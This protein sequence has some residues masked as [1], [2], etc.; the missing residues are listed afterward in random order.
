MNGKICV[1]YFSPTKT[2]GKIV[3]SLVNVLAQ[4]TGK[5]KV[6]IDL[7]L[8]G[9]RSKEYVFGPDDVLVFGFPVY[10]GR[11]PKLLQETLAKL[12]SDHSKA[13]IS[14]TYGNRE[15]E[16]ALLEAKDIIQT[17]GFT[18]VAACALIGEHSFS[19]KLAA[20]RPDEKDMASA[21]RFAQQIADK[22][23]AGNFQE[24]S[25]KG[26]QP[27]REEMPALPFLPKT[28]DACTNCLNCVNVCPLG[29]IDANDPKIVNTGCIQCC[30]CVKS[31]P[32]EAKYFDD[33]NLTKLVT[34]LENNFMARKEPEFFI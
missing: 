4:R 26:K 5:E 30:A 29:I 10:G 11:M 9:E 27:Y 21:G 28:K 22:L 7:T 2:T 12:K 34:M 25:V 19:R 3:T 13:I 1:M 15:Y 14:A 20:N 18:V 8:P 24:V 6:V 16:D 17:R 33:E 32:V 31:C 23:A